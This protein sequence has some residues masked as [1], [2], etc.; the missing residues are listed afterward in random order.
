MT[1]DPLPATATGNPAIAHDPL[2]ATA[3]GNPATTRSPLPPARQPLLQVE[4]LSKEYSVNSPWFGRRG[5]FTAVG[6]VSFSL[7]KGETLGLVGE[8]GSGK[9]TVARCLMQLERPSGGRVLLEGRD[10]T[11]LSQRELRP[12]RKV[13]QIIF[14]DPYSA[15]N[16]R[17]T[18]GRFV[19]DPILIHEG[20]QPRQALEQRV[21]ALFAKVGLDSSHIGRYPHEFSGGQRQRIC[22]A[23]ALAL[24]PRLIVADEPITALDVSIQAQ[25]INLLQQ[26]QD[27]QGLSYLFISHD[28]GMVRHICHR[29]AVM[30]R[31]LIVETGSVEDIFNDPRHPY[32]QAL[33]SATL[34]ADPAL[35]RGKKRV[36]YTGSPTGWQTAGY[37]KE[38]SA[39]HFVREETPVP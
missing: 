13:M 31:G 11:E 26:L 38:V 14:Q 16:P 17:M 25:I 8:S 15:L 34:E 18:A 19:A 39:G 32:T 22:I 23:R 10:L 24:S 9:S 30:L 12:L 20:R 6:G 2:P 35:E 37:M 27:E 21:R 4:G 3:T 1:H 33:L 7:E 28:L 5:V 36:F 29:V